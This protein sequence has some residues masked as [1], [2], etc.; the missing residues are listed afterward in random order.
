MTDSD[1]STSSPRGRREL[2]RA[3]FEALLA[4]LG[5]DR[6]QAGQAYEDLRRRLISLFSWEQ[7]EHPDGLA[8]EVLNRLSRRLAQGAAV[9]HI[10]RFAFGIARLVMQEEARGRRQR[11]TASREFESTRQGPAQVKAEPSVAD[12]VR[13]CLEALP[14]DRR[15]LI[16]RYYNGDREALAKELG[17]S[18]NALRNRAMRIRAGLARKLLGDRDKH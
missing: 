15:D 5:P 7:F 4:A 10:D 6:E 17:L 16:E 18:L 2:E 9:P 3:E 14:S 1:F 11:R 13:E 12:S 8:D